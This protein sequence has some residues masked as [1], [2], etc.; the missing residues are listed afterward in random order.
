MR[1]A[2]ARRSTWKGETMMQG[3]V[4]WTAVYL[5][6][7]IGGGAAVAA[8]AQ[9]GAAQ[10]GRCFILLFH[11]QRF[12]ADLYPVLRNQQFQAG[13]FAKQWVERELLPGD[14]VA[15]AGYDVKLKLY[16]DL[17]HDRAALAAAIDRAVNGQEVASNRPALANQAGDAPSLLAGLPRGDELRLRT[18][19]LYQGLQALAAAAGSIPARKD[20]I[21]FTTGISRVSPPPHS[22]YDRSLREY[23]PAVAALNRSE[24]AVYPIDLWTMPPLRHD[25]GDGLNQLANETGGRYLFHFT[26]FLSALEQIAQANNEVSGSTHR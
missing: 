7:L 13:V 9:G 6:A 19:T 8:A 23:L 24:V 17:T 4:R 10:N 16:Q 11:D 14:R 18:P 3:R 1:V 5:A 20:L 21:L 25:W 15:V 2:L 12:L 22:I 26:T